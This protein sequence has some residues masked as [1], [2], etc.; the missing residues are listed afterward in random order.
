M[1]KLPFL[2][3]L[4]IIVFAGC[5]KD[6]SNSDSSGN[7]NSGT[8]TIA[9]IIIDENNIAVASAT[10]T[11]NGY[12]ATSDAHGLFLLKNAKLNMTRCILKISKAG[13]INRTHAFIAT[14]QTVNYV[15]IILASDAITHTISSAAGGTISLADGSSV[16]FTPGSFVTAS[17]SMYSGTVNITFKH[18]SPDATGFGFMIPG[19]DLLGK[20]SLGEDVALYSYG[21]LGVI[22]KGSSGEQLQ[23]AIGSSATLTMPIAAS[24]ISTAPSS[25]PLLY[26]DET[27]SLWMQQGNA[28]RIGNNYVGIVSHFSWWNFDFCGSVSN[29][30]GKVVDC[31]GT[32]MPNINVSANG[33]GGVFTDANGKYHELCPANYPFNIQVLASNNSGLFSDS[34]I[35]SVPSLVV[36]Q[37]YVVPDLVFVT[38]SSTISGTLKNCSGWNTDG[39]VLAYWSG[40]GSYQYST[41]GSFNLYCPANTIVSLSASPTSNNYSIDSQ[42]TSPATGSILNVGDLIFCNSTSTENYF[43]LNGSGFPNQLFQI[44]TNQTDYASVYND[45]LSLYTSG[46]M[47]PNFTLSSFF[48]SVSGRTLQTYN[49]NSGSTSFRFM[50]VDPIDVYSFN[51]L[52]GGPGTITLTQVD[53]VGGRVKGTYSG[54]GN[55][56]KNGGA[57]SPITISGSFDVTR[58]E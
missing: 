3:L 39:T 4:C 37:T 19:N 36:G 16:Q 31:K 25:I 13:F 17:G 54:Q 18:L 33:R 58:T 23:L 50:F 51:S 7:G 53:S 38:C 21:M 48:M 2:F 42:Y 56:Q 27:T 11:S 8:T 35:E 26:F 20:N 5:K 41:N 40:G 47:A 28:I 15:K 57:P 52:I 49:W 32:P 30:K 9:G 44:Q 24:Q 22:L 46:T 12:S 29:V 6:E 14:E 45:S 10:I 55:I 1:R 34:Q 43:T